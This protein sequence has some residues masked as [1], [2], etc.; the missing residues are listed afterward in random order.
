MM[1]SFKQF[2]KAKTV[3]VP[4]ADYYPSHGVHSQ[5]KK[6]VPVADYTPS[7]GNHSMK[8]ETTK[9]ISHSEFTSH[10]PNSKIHPSVS[11]VHEKLEH[12]E[13][14]WNNSLKPH[15][16][17]A[18]GEYTASS[19]ASNRELI[20]T[21]HGRPSNFHPHPDDNTWTKEWKIGGKEK[22]EK[23]IKGLDS[24]LNRS[25]APRNLTVYH[26]INAPS[27]EKFNPGEA[28]SQ[29]PERHLRMPAY[30]STTVD[31]H[32][33]SAFA[34]PE[35]WEGDEKKP[36]TTHMLRIHLKRG[37]KGFKYVGDRS[38]LPG[39]REGILKRD[40]VLKI[41][42]HPTVVHHPET[43]GHIHVWD[44]HLVDHQKD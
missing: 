43:G 8:E 23:L 36:T 25:K 12:P 9:T 6:K 28:A 30:L 24:V 33:A 4:V 35:K 26:G 44:A 14:K 3:K 27:S 2:L 19:A 5:E 7:H 32:I 22:H 40:S 16:K 31:P 39:E 34:K 38:S 17:V 13:E 20:D 37:Q 21:A 18:I 15:E 1:K 42:E 10:N 29:H 41:A 11:G